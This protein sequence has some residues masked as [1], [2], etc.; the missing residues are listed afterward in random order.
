MSRAID[1]SFP[2]SSA[3]PTFPGDPA[4]RVRPVRTLERG[5]AYRLSTLALGSHSGTHLDAPSHFVAGGA[6]VDQVDLE[7]LNGEAHV[8]QVA[9]EARSVGRT[10][11]KGVPAGALRVLFRTANSRRFASGSG[12]F[13]D[14]V[15]LEPEAAERLLELGV[16]LVG[17][18]GLSVENDPSQRFPVHHR[19]LGAGCWILEG[20][21]LDGVAPGTH[22]IGCLPLRLEGADGSPCRAVL[23]E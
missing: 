18:D 7:L 2:L 15:G 9:E 3:C 16:R 8:V 20:L 12:F 10:E 21:R 22:R 19:L 11:L 4:I 17:V 13:A 23:W 14:Y 6:S 1:L 5:D